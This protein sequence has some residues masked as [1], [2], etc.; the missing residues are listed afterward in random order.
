MLVRLRPSLDLG[1]G[2]LVGLRLRRSL[3]LGLGL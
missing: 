1:L 2:L 3:D